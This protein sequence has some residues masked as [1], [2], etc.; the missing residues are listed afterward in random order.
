MASSS[1]SPPPDVEAIEVVLLAK[2]QTATGNDRRCPGGEGAAEIS[3][4]DL[5]L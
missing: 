3:N 4:R 1:I 2:I 5:S